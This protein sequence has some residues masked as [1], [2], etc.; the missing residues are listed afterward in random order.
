MRFPARAE[1][2]ESDLLKFAW[3]LIVTLVMGVVGFYT[4]TTRRELDEMKVNHDKLWEHHD[5]DVKKLATLEAE[6][7]HVRGDLTEIK[8]MLKDMNQSIL[9]LHRE[10]HDSGR[11]RP[12]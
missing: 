5:E 4:K 8:V 2:A 7:R 3:G 9:A 10:G 12:K 6:G 11:G 1:V